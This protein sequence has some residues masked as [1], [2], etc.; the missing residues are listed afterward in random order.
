MI[1][2]WFVA[3]NSLWI[4]GLS[5]LLATVSWASWTASMGESRMAAALAQP[6]ARRAWAAGIALF[7]AGM[8]VTGRAWWEQGLWGTL[9]AGAIVCAFGARMER[10]R[11]KKGR[12]P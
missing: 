12:T 11:G 7:C 9:A 6:G 5:L 3:S 4:A 2:L 1:D 10:A 8:A